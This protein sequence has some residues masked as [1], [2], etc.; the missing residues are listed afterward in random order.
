MKRKK[1]R[2]SRETGKGANGDGTAKSNQDSGKQNDG[3]SNQKS[4]SG[5]VV[6]SLVAIRVIG[7]VTG[8]FPF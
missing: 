7:R 4:Y 6:R 8:L 5:L 3:D 1:S 2:S